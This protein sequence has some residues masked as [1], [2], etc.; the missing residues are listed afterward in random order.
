MKQVTGVQLLPES[1]RDPQTVVGP[2]GE[3]VQPSIEGVTFRRAISQAD[4]RGTLTEIFSL[5]WGTETEPPPHVY[6]VRALPGSIRSWIVHLEQ[7]DRLYFSEGLAK[8][9]LFDARE[10]SPSFGAA[11]VRY[12]GAHEPGLLTIP[13]GI[14]HGVRNVGNEVLRYVNLPTKPYDYGAPDKY[15][16]PD[17]HPRI[18]IDL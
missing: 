10:S 7:N 16:L 17:G 2:S 9:G 8:V 12:L 14:Y 15:R 4:G 1:T 11:V 13:A 5:S 3:R 6:E 18:P